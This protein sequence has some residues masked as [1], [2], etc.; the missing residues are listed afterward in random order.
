MNGQMR[1]RHDRT[2]KVYKTHL[3]TVDILRLQHDLSRQRQRTVQPAAPDHTAVYFHIKRSVF[4]RTQHRMRLD[5]EAGKI[6]MRRSQMKPA[7]RLLSQTERQQRRAESTDIIRP[8]RLQRPVCT[9]SELFKT[10]PPQTI[11]GS[12]NRMK[13]G[14][15]F[16][17]NGI[18][19]SC[20]L[21]MFIPPVPVLSIRPVSVRAPERSPRAFETTDEP[22]ESAP[23]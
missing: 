17:Q 13:R 5:P 19:P 11:C 10:S 12:L 18:S 23:G 20:M 14:N 6:G 15:R 3:R 9:Q 7:A 4:A 22:G 1:D 2:S 8:P 16:L 21:F